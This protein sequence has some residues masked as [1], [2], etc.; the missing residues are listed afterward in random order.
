M[1]WMDLCRVRA[2]CFSARGRCS[3]AH[4]A[5]ILEIQIP[6]FRFTFFIC[7]RKSKH[8]VRL[9]D[10]LFSIILAGLEGL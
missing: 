5:V 6:R 2:I 10:G 8:G 9:G 1:D 3:L 7:Q 4:G